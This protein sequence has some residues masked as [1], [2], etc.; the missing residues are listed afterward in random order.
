LVE[1]S[2][3]T[4]RANLSPHAGQRQ[5]PAAKPSERRSTTSI[6]QSVCRPALCHSRANLCARC[7][8]A[9]DGRRL[10]RL[11]LGPSCRSG[12]AFGLAV[13]TALRIRWRRRGPLYPAF[14]SPPQVISESRLKPNSLAHLCCS[15]RTDRPASLPLHI[16][17]GS[18]GGWKIGFRR[19]CRPFNKFTTDRQ[20]HI[21][22]GSLPNGHASPI[23]SF[24]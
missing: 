12:T 11:L 9:Y 8:S 10:E 7:T 4:S 6:G 14:S 24:P 22:T 19:K 2:L 13:V 3:A 17:V 5:P 20:T 23:C 15:P 1:A 16:S 21:P 18:I